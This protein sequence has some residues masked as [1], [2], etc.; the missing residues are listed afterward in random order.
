MPPATNQARLMML[1]LKTG[2][3]VSGL[4][5]AY[6]ALK[7]PGQAPQPVNPA[8]EWAICAVAVADDVIGLLYGR[9]LAGWIRRRAPRNG[10]LSDPLQVWMV[11]NMLSLAL[12]ESCTLFGLV[13]HFVG[14]G[15]RF[16]GVLL[17]IGVLSV[18]F[19]SPGNPPAAAEERPFQS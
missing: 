4:L 1:F 18:I 8:F 5:F 16:A 19:W 15:A 10:P 17:S 7:L 11:G 3:I 13:L 6:L 12:M 2:F 14:A 9:K